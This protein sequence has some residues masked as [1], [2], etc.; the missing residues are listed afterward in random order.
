LVSLRS[1]KF[2][3]LAARGGGLANITVTFVAL[4]YGIGLLTAAWVL[5]RV[6][7]G[8]FNPAITLGMVLAGALPPLR[9]LILF[10]AQLLGAICAAAVVSCIAPIDID[11]VQTKLAPDTSV[12]QGV[13]LEMVYTTTVAP[14]AR[15]ADRLTSSF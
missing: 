12:A 1:V 5:Y 6:S 10:P 8:L 15:C 4:S 9:G 13:F 3:P 7:G 11:M 14:T 2:E